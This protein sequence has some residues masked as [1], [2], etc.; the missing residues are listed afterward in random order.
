MYMKRVLI[1]STAYHP[2]VGGAEVAIREIT[3]RLQNDYAFDMIT[4]R[5]DWRLPRIERVGAVNVHRIGFGIPIVDKLLLP[6]WGAITALRL[7]AKNQYLCFWGAM[8]TFASGAAYVSNLI[9]FWNKV[10]MVLTLQEGDSPAYI[11]KKWFGLLGLSWRLALMR[12]DALTVISTY[13]GKLAQSYGYK[14]AIEVVPNGADIMHFKGESIVHNG[15]ILITTSRL[16][17]KNAIDDVIRALPILPDIRFQVLGTG[18]LNAELKTLAQKEGVQ[19]RVEFL[20]HI[21]Y[22][23]IPRHLHAA[24]IFIR[25][26][27]SEGMGNSFIEAM[28]AG[29]PVIATQEGGIADFLF[30]E[31]RNPDKPTT[32]WAV[33]KNSPEQIAEAVNDILARPE[34]VREVVA[35][36]K[37][38]VSEK[39]D[40][41]IIAHDMH[42]RVFQR[43]FALRK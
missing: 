8:I 40:W 12:T 41:D 10:H 32:G 9:H 15:T 4:A 43:L 23:D 36:A 16:A 21:D 29:L 26:S 27:R 42:K 11:R 20:G 17:H 7:N 5:L 37:K 13:L 6:F 31:K 2:F 1:F 28:A 25:P 3:K 34:K 19:G 35:T 14:G 30:D 38:M 24:D 18:P 39:Y 33:D 22:A